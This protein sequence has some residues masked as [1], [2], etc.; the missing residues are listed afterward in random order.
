MIGL[1]KIPRASVSSLAIA[2]LT[3]QARFER[4]AHTLGRADLR[5]LGHS[6]GGPQ[7]RKEWLMR[8]NWS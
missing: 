7:V 1:C 3:R 4:R 8:G 5:E 2:L 6:A